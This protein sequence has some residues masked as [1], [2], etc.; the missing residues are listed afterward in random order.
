MGKGDKWQPVA[1]LFVIFL[2]VLVGASLTVCS[3]RPTAEIDRR[4]KVAY[5]VWCK[6]NPKVSITQEEW[7]IATQRGV[8]K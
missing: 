1:I 3:T 8:I 2:L 4:T 6:M 7:E 5:G